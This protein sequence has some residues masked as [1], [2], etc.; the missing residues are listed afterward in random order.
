MSDSKNA[1]VNKRRDIQRN[2]KKNMSEKV[3]NSTIWSSHT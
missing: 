2:K 1:T 3:I